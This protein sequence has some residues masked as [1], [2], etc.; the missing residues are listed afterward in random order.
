MATKLFLRTTQNNGIGATYFDMLAVAGAGSVTADVTTTASGTEI[1][2][3][4]TAGGAELLFISGRAPVGGFT[5]TTTDISIWAHESG[6]GVN[7]G[8]AYRIFKRA[9]DT[10]ETELAGGLYSDGVEFT[11]TTPTEMLWTGNPTDTAFAEDDRI[12]LK[13]KAANVGT[14]GAGTATLT[15]NAADAA[16]GDS[17]F[18]IAETVTFKAEDPPG[19]TLR[20][21]DWPN[22]PPPKRLPAGLAVAAS[23]LVT[24]LAPNLI[25]RAPVYA[26]IRPAPRVQV[27]Q[28]PPNLLLTTLAV[29][30]AAAPFT[31]QDWPNPAKAAQYRYDPRTNLLVTTLAPSEA[32][33][34]VQNNWPNPQVRVIGQP[35]L[36]PNLLALNPSKGIPFQQWDWPNPISFRTLRIAD[37]PNLTINLP[38]AAPF[39]PVD[40]PNPQRPQAPP[41]WTAPYF[42]Q[43]DPCPA[44][45]YF[46]T[47]AVNDASAGDVA[48]SNPENALVSDNVY[49]TVVLVA[50]SSQYVVATNFGFNIA[51]Q[52][53]IQGIVVHTEGKTLNGNVSMSAYVV[54]GGVIRQETVINVNWTTTESL[55]QHGL[56]TSLW[57][58]NWTP[59]DINAS[60]FGAAIQRFS[61]STDTLSLDSLRI[62]V[63]CADFP[64]SLSDWPA[65][66]SL[67]TRQTDNPPNLLCT[68]LA[69]A[70]TA[71]PF[72]QADWPNPP[73][74]KSL[75]VQEQQS[76][77][78]LDL[79]T[80]AFRQLDWPNPVRA[81]AA[82]QPDNPPNLVVTA[83]APTPLEVFRQ[84]EWPSP[85]AAKTTRVEVLPNLTI[86]LPI[87]P[88]APPI[89]PID[90]PNPA[91]QKASRVD[92]PLNLLTT[93]LAPTGEKP[94]SQGNWPNPQKPPSFRHPNSYRMS[95]GE[96]GAPI[97]PPIVPIAWPNPRKPPELIGDMHVLN[98]ALGTMP[99]RQTDWPN[100]RVEKTLRVDIPPNLQTLVFAPVPP[101]PFAQTD[102]PNPPPRK[103]IRVIDPPNL[104]TSSLFVP[105]AG[106]FPQLHW[107]NPQL[108]KILRIDVLP[109][110]TIGLPPPVQAP[111]SWIDW[112]LARV[113]VRAQP[114]EPPNLLL[115]TLAIP[116]APLPF[117]QFDWPNPPPAKSIRVDNPPNLQTTTFVPVV[118]LP[119]NQ[120]DWPLP[121]PTDKRKLNL[122]MLTENVVLLTTPPP[123]VATGSREKRK[124]RR[125]SA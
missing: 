84:T 106:P 58:N 18:N 79:A 8:G 60:N 114:T 85:T 72:S 75:P 40:W 56:P 20:P 112:P 124:W 30:P 10:T 33:P 69:V 15:Y 123:V 118:S 122:F 16:T 11:K 34:F 63:Y 5:L 57:D 64:F 39:N 62:T 29:A 97:G 104:L 89:V 48:W 99:F 92:N 110:L 96:P 67:V 80:N 120:Y 117:S 38:I 55:H 45:P 65:P 28:T 70:V 76:L 52:K 98:L 103:V 81:K 54:K 71:I 25:V 115:S 1:Q 82:S 90:W 116:P 87:A 68:T 14:M 109:N 19:L 66:R 121:A 94:F 42:R 105:F 37:P 4:Q 49:S 7:A 47:L 17:F 78:T 107:P 119:F 111:F 12:L 26:N 77:I 27:V 9:A 3:T 108:A 113:T 93:T 13:I 101:P 36:P 41:Q 125:G 32:A 50:Q 21:K 53:I 22:P 43:Y 74:L 23:L 61:T 2:W 24:T 31:Q 73:K 6:T 59:A 88:I 83:S 46:G 91:P 95:F 100:P 35:D 51:P 102:W 86:S 44:G